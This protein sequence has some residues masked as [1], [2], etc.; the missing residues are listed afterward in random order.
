MKIES[1]QFELSVG[2]GSQLP[3]SQLPEVAVS[4]RS[5]V[6][7]SSLINRIVGEKRLIVSNIP[8]TTRDAVDTVVTN[9]YGTYTFIDTAGI[10]RSSK[11][12]D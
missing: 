11:I 12:N 6:G 3:P 8:G 4:G 7:K 10:R 2:L 9:S 1:A 5:N